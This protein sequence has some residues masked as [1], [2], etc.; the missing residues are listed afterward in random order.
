MC[1][2]YTVQIDMIELHERFK[3]VLNDMYGPSSNCAP[4][5]EL[6]VVTNRA[7]EEV[8]YYRWGLVPFWAK[9]LKIGYKMINARAETITDKK[10]FSA[11][12][13]KRR[14]LVLAD[15]FYEWKK[16]DKQ[17]KQPYRIR[18]QGGK[19]FA[20]AGIWEHNKGLQVNS[21]AIITTDANEMVNQVHDRMPVILK[22]ED[23]QRWLSD[24]LDLKEAVDLLQ[25]YPAEAMEMYPVNPAVG[26]ARNK[27]PE[28]TQPWHGA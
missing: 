10:S 17:N 13:Q 14:C 22:P 11:P 19:P 21:Y 9:D 1:G 12:L 23:E 16:L 3:V 7:P 8:N 6:P 27:D 15:S 25:P 20:F 4:T 24:S 5:E 18:L 26:N 28:L 2:R